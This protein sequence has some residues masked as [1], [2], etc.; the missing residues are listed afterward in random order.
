VN[1]ESTKTGHETPSQTHV[2]MFS[3]V[4]GGRASGNESTKKAKPAPATVTQKATARNLPTLNV[5]DV[6]MWPNVES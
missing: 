4:V 3:N 5:G 2:Q 1:A 6:V